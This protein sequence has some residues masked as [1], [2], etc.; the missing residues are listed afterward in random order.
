MSTEARKRWEQ[1]NS[2]HL[3]EYRHR[4]Y[5]ENKPELLAKQTAYVKRRL[6]GPEGSSLREYKY[7]LTSRWRKTERGKELNRMYMR[8]RTQQLREEMLNVFGNRCACCGEDR[9]P[10]LTLDHIGGGGLAHRKSV[11]N[12]AWAVLNSVKKLGWPKDKFR[13][14]CMNC[15]FATRSGRECPH[16]SMVELVAMAGAPCAILN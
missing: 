8:N 15:N 13:I 16:D 7:A 1:E 2:E 9:K 14:L 11:G 5:E 3:R 12:A 10:F 4:Y 6:S